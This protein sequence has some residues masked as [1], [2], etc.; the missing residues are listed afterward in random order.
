MDA[1]F[2]VLST[3]AVVLACILVPTAII[4]IASEIVGNVRDKATRAD[5]MRDHIRRMRRVRK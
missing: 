5:M 4:S 3:L 2:F 1:L